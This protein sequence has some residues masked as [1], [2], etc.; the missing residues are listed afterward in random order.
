MAG[1]RLTT[2]EKRY[3]TAWLLS[4]RAHFVAGVVAFGLFAAAMT[5]YLARVEQCDCARTNAENLR[6]LLRAAIGVFCV[7]VA[8]MLLDAFVYIPNSAAAVALFA[9]IATGWLL[10]MAL[11]G[12]VM[13]WYAGTRDCDCARSWE[14]HA[15]FGA[16]VLVALA[17]VA[18]FA[19]GKARWASYWMPQISGRVV[20]LGP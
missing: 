19:T 20:P 9:V 16:S 7:K 17:T 1:Y 3:K 2:A 15:F 8:A 10:D 12:T 5:R 4:Q 11:A 14:R 18:A 13:K 6:W